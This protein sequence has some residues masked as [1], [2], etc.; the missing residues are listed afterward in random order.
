M[1]LSYLKL[2]LKINNRLHFIGVILNAPRLFQRRRL[3]V[4]FTFQYD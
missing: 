1:S 4:F 3:G 2:T